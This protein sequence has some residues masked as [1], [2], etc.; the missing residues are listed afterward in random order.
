MSRTVFPI[1]FTFIGLSALK[2]SSR[3]ADI[4]KWLSV[5]VISYLRQLPLLLMLALLYRSCI[6]Y[7]RVLY[8]AVILEQIDK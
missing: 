7:S 3:T 4:S 6:I 1:F 5:I 2:G 8:R